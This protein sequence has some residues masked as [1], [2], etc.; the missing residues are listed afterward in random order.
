MR[1]D[2]WRTRGNQRSELDTFFGDLA[3]WFVDFTKGLALE[4]IKANLENLEESEEWDNFCE[5]TSQ[6]LVHNMYVSN[7]RTWREA[8]RKSSNGG[9]I[10]QLLNTEF[11][12]NPQFLE[13][14]NASKNDIK[15]LPGSISAKVVKKAQDLTLE[16]VR[17]SDA[18]KDIQAL[19][20][21]Y[22]KASATLIARTQIAKTQ[23]AI[24]QVR[25][26]QLGVNWYTWYTVGGPLVRSSHRHMHGVLCNFNSPPN[27]EALA[28]KGKSVSFYNPGGI[29][30]CRCYAEPLISI[31]DIKKWP[32][33]VHYGNRIVYMTKRRFM[34]IM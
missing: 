4:D 6:N 7:A 17:Y 23:A 11:I 28:G 30:N 9:K 27:P 31:D 21:S 10:L 29:Y 22:S 14:V 26:Q 16:G 25:S 24:T 32:A 33:K 8:A 34:E 12:N 3:N 18:I 13:L 20:P 15:T 5:Q 1:N 19:I 2:D